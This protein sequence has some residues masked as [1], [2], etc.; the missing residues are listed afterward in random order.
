MREPGAHSLVRDGVGAPLPRTRCCVHRHDCT[1]SF[2]AR[3]PEELAAE[4]RNSLRR[5]LRPACSSCS[6]RCR[7][8]G[9]QDPASPCCGVY[10]VL[11]VPQPCS[12]EVGSLS[13]EVLGIKAPSR[14][15][16]SQTCSVG[17]VTRLSCLGTH[18][19]TA[20][21]AHAGQ[22]TG[23]W[24]CLSTGCSCPFHCAP[25]SFPLSSPSRPP[26]STLLPVALCVPLLWVTGPLNDRG[27]VPCLFLYL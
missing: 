10:S 27:F 14:S 20:Y 21:T 11:A 26:H 9:P 12:Q 22:E 5:G 15:A 1:H 8:G 6:G 18:G 2:P 23:P 3:N 17:M 13:G 7:T 25:V 24:H 19:V 16:L 4:T